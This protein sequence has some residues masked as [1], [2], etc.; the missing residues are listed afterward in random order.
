M[1]ALICGISGQDGAYLSQFL[2]NKGY[3]VYGTSRDINTRGFDGLDTLG[4]RDKVQLL[5]MSVVDFRSVIQV[6]QKVRPEEIYNLTGQSSVG[7]SFD[8]PVETFESIS[9][10]TLNLLEA[11]R[12]H[13]SDIRLYNAGSG[14]CFGNTGEHAADE[15][16]R[17]TPSSPY[18]VAKSTAYWTVATYREAYKLY[19]TT[20]LLF[21]H[22]SPLRPARFVTRKIVAAAVRI[23]EGAGEKLAL[24]NLDIVRDWGWAPEYV[25]AMWKMLQ[26]PKPGDFVI[27]SG[28]SFS[29]KEFVAAAFSAVGL[30]WQDH[31]TSDPRLLRPYDHM[32]ARAN[33]AKAANELG[34]QAKYTMPDVIRMMVAAERKALKE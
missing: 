21:N 5:S 18:A 13:Q 19:A 28:K 3:E 11:I 17:L 33:P 16:T 31:V 14:E 23:A 2:L 26:Q 15:T 4:I 8:Q 34:W 6:L 12:F 1:R 9:V 24:G 10:G 20:G 29:L 7:L 22:E 30:K 32:V 27:A 25:E